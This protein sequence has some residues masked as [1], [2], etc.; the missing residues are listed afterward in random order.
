MGVLGIA[1]SLPLEHSRFHSSHERERKRNSNSCSM[2]VHSRP[3]PLFPAQPTGTDLA[4]GDRL[5]SPGLLRAS[6]RPAPLPEQLVSRC[7][8]LSLPRRT[9]SALW[10]QAV[11]PR[12][13]GQTEDWFLLFLGSPRES[14]MPW[15]DLLGTRPGDRPSPSLG[16]G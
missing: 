1:L 3:S 8:E 6:G 7:H 15:G 2:L 13:L 11:P 5:N 4:F 14:W 9:V 10:W 16:G 12:P